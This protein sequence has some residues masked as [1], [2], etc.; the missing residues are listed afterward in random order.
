MIFRFYRTHYLQKP[1][2]V[3]RYP[4]R[5]VLGFPSQ[6]FYRICSLFWDTLN[7][8]RSV[9]QPFLNNLSAPEILK[10]FEQSHSSAIQ[11][12][13]FGE[14]RWSSLTTTL[15]GKRFS[16]CPAKISTNRSYI[17]S[18]PK[19]DLKFSRRWLLQPSIAKAVWKVFYFC[20]WSSQK[21][22]W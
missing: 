20:R 6:Y 21:E 11:R 16:N 19:F 18:R 9:L 8:T 13:L 2:Q 22:T 12:N 7:Q 15:I 17:F 1:K 14:Q 4:Y 3:F 5:P 10:Q